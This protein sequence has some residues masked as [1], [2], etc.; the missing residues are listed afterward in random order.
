MLLT[1]RQTQNLLCLLAHV[2]LGSVSLDLC[3]ALVAERPPRILDK[4][5]VR[6]LLVTH[7]TAEALRVPGRIHGLDDTANDELP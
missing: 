1:I 3:V 7:L 2:S 5:Q 4:A 6:K